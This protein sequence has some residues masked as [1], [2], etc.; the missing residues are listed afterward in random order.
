MGAVLA[1]FVIVS[2]MVAVMAWD[3]RNTKPF[4]V[5]GRYLRFV[6]LYALPTTAFMGVALYGVFALV[7][8]GTDWEFIGLCLGLTFF[9]GAI[10]GA[11]EASIP[12]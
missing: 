11:A 2:L 9:L 6:A 3:L 12:D 1:V 10:T 8:A 7:G 4:R 5:L